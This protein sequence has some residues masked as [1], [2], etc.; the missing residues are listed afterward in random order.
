MV[1]LAGGAGA[2]AA[3]LVLH[4]LGETGGATEVELQASGGVLNVDFQLNQRTYQ[5]VHLQGPATFIFSGTIT[6]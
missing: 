6:L 4:F 1:T 3:A 2:V 5:N